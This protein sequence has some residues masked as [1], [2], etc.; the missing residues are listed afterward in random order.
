MNSINKTKVKLLAVSQHRRTVFSPA[1]RHWLKQTT[2]QREQWPTLQ[3]HR[4]GAAVVRLSVK[5]SFFMLHC[6][7]Y[8]NR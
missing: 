3:G 5:P 2:A 8:H 1:V 6:S 7:L 4:K